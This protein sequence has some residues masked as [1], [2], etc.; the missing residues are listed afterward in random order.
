[1]SCSGLST[2]KQQTVEIVLTIK[3]RE[4]MSTNNEHT[5]TNQ[6]LIRTFRAIEDESERVRRMAVLVVHAVAEE[7][8]SRRLLGECLVQIIQRKVLSQG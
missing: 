6:E 3:A 2:V 5:R 4:I 1:M 8:E 7:H